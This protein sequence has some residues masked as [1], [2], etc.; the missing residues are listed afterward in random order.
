M[1]GPHRR[2]ASLLLRQ[3]KGRAPKERDAIRATSDRG[4]PVIQ[5]QE[6]PSQAVERRNEAKTECRDFASWQ[7]QY[8]LPGRAHHRL[9]LR[10][11]QTDLEYHKV[12]SRQKGHRSYH[13]FYGRS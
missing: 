2:R 3:N 12:E 13:T 10:E 4:G 5:V 9:G 8:H 11:S 6:V 1:A 7:S